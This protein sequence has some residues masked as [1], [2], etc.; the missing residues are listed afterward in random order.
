VDG[1]LDSPAIQHEPAEKQGGSGRLV[2]LA[3]SGEYAR[4]AGQDTVRR[5]MSPASR[6]HLATVDRSL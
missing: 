6:K 5:R 1:G 4:G 3:S 2:A